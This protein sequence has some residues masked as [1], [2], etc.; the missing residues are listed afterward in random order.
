METASPAT[1]DS[2]PAEQTPIFLPGGLS[3][4]EVAIG[5]ICPWVMDLPHIISLFEAREAGYTVLI[6]PAGP[7]LDI[8]R[9]KVVDMFLEREHCKW[10]V[11]IDSDVK[12]DHR[13]IP[14]LIADPE[15]HPVVSGIYHNNFPHTGHAPLVYRWNPES[16]LHENFTCREIGCCPDRPVHPDLPADDPARVADPLPRDEYG[17]VKIDGFGAGYLAIHRDVLEHMRDRYKVATFDGNGST[18][19]AYFIEQTLP[20]GCWYGEDFMFALRCAND[21]GIQLYA[22]PD[23]KGIHFKKV[24]L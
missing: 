3:P 23:V 1:L 18:A 20:N 6:V 16:T 13:D 19:Q 22:H 8:E 21:L 9:N 2:S 10:L 14:K 24:G 4:H 17:M 7:Y 12:F 11:F 5:V 15:H